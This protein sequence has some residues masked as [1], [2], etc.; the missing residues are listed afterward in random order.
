MREM[1]DQQVIAKIQLA[2][3]TSTLNR[4]DYWRMLASPW[5]RSQGQGAAGKRSCRRSPIESRRASP[6]RRSAKED[7]GQFILWRRECCE[8]SRLESANDC[9]AGPASSADE[10]IFSGE[11]C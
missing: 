5:G 6:G 11:D 4:G 9:T 7:R 10:S 8:E 2:I 3:Y 1:W